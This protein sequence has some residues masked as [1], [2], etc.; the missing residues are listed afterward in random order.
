[1]ILRSGHCCSCHSIPFYYFLCILRVADLTVYM[2]KLLIVAM[3]GLHGRERHRWRTHLRIELADEATLL[4]TVVGTGG[5]VKLMD[6][7]DVDKVILW[8]LTTGS[9]CKACDDRAA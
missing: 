8:Y 1:M 4:H 5:A 7:P 3:W 9:T 6:L 2:I